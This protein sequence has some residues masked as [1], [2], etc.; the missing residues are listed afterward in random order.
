MK[1][2]SLNRK[3]KFE[4]WGAF[5]PAMLERF[6]KGDYAE[7]L[8]VACEAM[9]GISGSSYLEDEYDWFVSPDADPEDKMQLIG[10]FIGGCIKNNEN[11]KKK[12]LGIVDMTDESESNKNKKN[13]V[14]DLAL[15]VRE[16]AY[17]DIIDTCSLAQELLDLDDARDYIMDVEG[18]DIYMFILHTVSRLRGSALIQKAAV[19]RLKNLIASYNMANLIMSVMQ[20]EGAIDYIEAKVQGAC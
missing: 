3:N 15:A 14:S 18:V 1:V 5:T 17:D 9:L 8:A 12:V 20:V 6:T 4:F 11:N 2:F 13:C 7:W 19:D 16:K 10:G